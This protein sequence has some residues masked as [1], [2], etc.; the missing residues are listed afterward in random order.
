MNLANIIRKTGEVCEEICTIGEPKDPLSNAIY[1][2]IDNANAETKIATDN[3]EKRTSMPISKYS[4]SLENYWR[5][6]RII[7][8]K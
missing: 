6:T 2:V 4:T 8:E 1:H 7:C 5:G 3:T